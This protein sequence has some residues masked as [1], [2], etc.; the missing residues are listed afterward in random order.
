MSHI[1][2][3]RFDRL[4]EAQAALQ[5]LQAE[6]FR[7]GEFDAFY[8]GPPG[9]HD[10]SPIGGDAHSDAGAQRGSSGAVLG[11]VAGGLIGVCIGALISTI[12]DVAP[13]APLIGFA[14]VG[15]YLGSLGGALKRF[16]GARVS[17]ASTGHP[18][19]TRGGEVVAVRADE[20]DDEP[21]AIAV[22][23]RC[24]ARDLGV[25]E[26]DWRDGS[27]RDFDPRLPLRPPRN[28]FPA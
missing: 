12:F 24:G 13:L 26:G 9:Q 2:A 10:L 7:Q 15:A 20:A 8:V 3:G 17:E 16:R 1:V 19:E 22:L 25:A 21:R 18:V 14:A 4:D 11:A 27:W 28:R 5:A 23:R 6:G